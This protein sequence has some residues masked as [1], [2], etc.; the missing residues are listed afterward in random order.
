VYTFMDD[1]SHWFA[2]WLR[3]HGAEE[4]EVESKVS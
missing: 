3:P 1:I 4:H 2:S